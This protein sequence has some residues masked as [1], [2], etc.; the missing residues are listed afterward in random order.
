MLLH[1]RMLTRISSTRGIGLKENDY[2]LGYLWQEGQLH[3]ILHLNTHSFDMVGSGLR[4]VL[5]NA[6]A[7][8]ITKCFNTASW[9][10]P[11]V[12][13]SRKSPQGSFV[14][15]WQPFHQPSLYHSFLFFFLSDRTGLA[16][17]FLFAY[18]GSQVQ[19]P[20]MMYAAWDPILTLILIHHAAGRTC[21]NLSKVQFEPREQVWPLK[22][23]K[24]IFLSIKV[25]MAL[26]HDRLVSEFPLQSCWMISLE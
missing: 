5:L 11:L 1:K 8:Y 20:P 24:I 6:I 10:L 13:Q 16:A 22:N 3:T 18:F 4:P 9:V 19:D 14:K 7:K 17:T 25:T 21:T 2:R 26:D 23:S 12:S 15:S